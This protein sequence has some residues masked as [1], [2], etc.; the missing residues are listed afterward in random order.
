M[1]IRAGRHHRLDNAESITIYQASITSEAIIATTITQKGQVTIP[2]PI[3]DHL[4]LKPGSKV[5]FKRAAD[6]SIVIVPADGKPPGSRF[7]ALRGHAGPGLSTDQIME[8][9]RGE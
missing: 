9:T 6:G 4:G 8:M 1:P 7:E 3:R 2:K 5:E